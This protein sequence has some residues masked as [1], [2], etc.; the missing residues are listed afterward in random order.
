MSNRW[1]IGPRQGTGEA[2]SCQIAEEISRRRK[3]VTLRAMLLRMTENRG[4]S[5]AFYSKRVFSGLCLDPFVS[6]ISFVLNRDSS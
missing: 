1:G 5:I 4:P 3:R 2:I 6:H